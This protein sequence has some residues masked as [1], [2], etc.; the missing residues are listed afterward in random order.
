HS[1]PTRRSS[2]LA[3]SGSVVVSPAAAS[4]LTIQTQPSGTATAGV[5]FTQQPVIRIEDQYG[6]LR[7][8]DNS[9]VVTAARSGGS[10]TLQGTLTTTATSAVEPHSGLNHQVAT[11]ITIAFSSGALTSATSE[12]GRA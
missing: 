1:S 2:D 12:I 5:A 9:T 11:T 6:N 7:S 3:T 4:Q 10:G 8:A